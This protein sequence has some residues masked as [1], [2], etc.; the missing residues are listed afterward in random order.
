MSVLRHKHRVCV[1]V[2][3]LGHGGY[4]ISNRT[5]VER[6]EVGSVTSTSKL[7]SQLQELQNLYPRVC[8][9]L[10]EAAAKEGRKTWS[11]KFCFSSVSGIHVVH[12]FPGPSQVI[13]RR[14]L[15]PDSF[16]PVSM[17]CSASPS[18]TLP[19]CWLRWVHLKPCEV[20]PSPSLSSTHRQC[21]QQR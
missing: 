5:V 16:L 12:L 8:V 19:P 11:V 10:E 18:P 3:P 1:L 13:I 14:Q 7:I 21:S 17:S 6:R 4:V 2:C 20:T 9:I 15:C